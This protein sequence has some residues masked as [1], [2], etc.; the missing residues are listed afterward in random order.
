ME[1]T[2]KVFTEKLEVDLTQPSPI[3]VRYS[4]YRIVELFKELNFTVGAEIGTEHGR[5]AA[6]LCSGNPQL[7]LYCIDPYSV[8]PYFKGEKEQEEV[9]SFYVE[10]QKRLKRFDHEILRMTSMEAVKQFEPNSLDF[11]FIDGNHFFEFVVNDIIHWS[12]IVKPGGIVY[13]HDYSLPDF[14]VKQAVNAFMDASQINPW[15]ILKSRG[16]II[17]CWM[18]VRQEKD[19]INYDV[20]LANSRKEGK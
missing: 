8:Y 6:M 1:N 15:F 19:W 12:R 10:A 4:R 7:K 16:N 9:E 17:D 13:G 14:H 3:A 2:L 5:Y 20:N 11:V 18:Y